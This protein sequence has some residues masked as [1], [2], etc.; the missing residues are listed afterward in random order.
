MVFHPRFQQNVKLQIRD[1]TQNF[2][3]IKA[4]VN[5]LTFYTFYSAWRFR[6][7]IQVWKSKT[8]L[9][10]SDAKAF[11]SLNGQ[12]DNSVFCEQKNQT[13]EPAN[14]YFTLLSTLYFAVT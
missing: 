4:A 13:V 14:V 8:L 2:V 11:V 9:M 3:T 6:K 12:T 10:R 5:K 1:L 7:V